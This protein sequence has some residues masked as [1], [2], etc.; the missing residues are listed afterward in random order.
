MSYDVLNSSLLNKSFNQC[1]VILSQAHN[2]SMPVISTQRNYKLH[3]LLCLQTQSIDWSSI[4]NETIECSRRW[5]IDDVTKSVRRQEP[6]LNRIATYRE[7][8]QLATR[9][10]VWNAVTLIRR[11]DD[12]SFKISTQNWR[13]LASMWDNFI[14][15]LSSTCRFKEYRN[16]TL[17][18]SG[19][20]KSE[21][22]LE[23]VV[24][25]GDWVPVKITK[26]RYHCKVINQSRIS[27][28]SEWLWH[29]NLKCG[30]PSLS[31]CHWQIAGKRFVGSQWIFCSMLFVSE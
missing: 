3:L 26:Q 16:R 6:R 2:V 9:L 27:Q 12:S 11:V 24:L 30:C 28:S 17:S 1:S 13:S 15:R 5:V 29:I 7:Q 21:H 4:N 31:V 25:V 23:T 14:D 18:T 19:T 8:F 22:H 20:S 10:A